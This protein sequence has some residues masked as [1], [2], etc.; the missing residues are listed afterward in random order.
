MEPARRKNITIL[1]M[2]K[3][4]SRFLCDHRTTKAQHTL[5]QWLNKGRRQ[6]ALFG[7]GAAHRHLPKQVII[8]RPRRLG[9]RDSIFGIFCFTTFYC[10]ISWQKYI[11]IS[12]I[13]QCQEGNAPTP[14]HNNDAKWVLGAKMHCQPSSGDLKVNSFYNALDKSG[15]KPSKA[16]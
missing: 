3:L 6:P 7:S 4:S 2:I 16:S 5:R 10:R 12:S 9:A 11:F 8:T 13:P 14:A 1:H 15:I